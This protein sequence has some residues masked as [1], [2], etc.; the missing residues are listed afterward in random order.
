MDVLGF[1]GRGVWKCSVCL[2]DADLP[3]D[4]ET[5]KT[6]EVQI[7]DKHK[8]TRMRKVRKVQKKK[9]KANKAVFGDVRLLIIVIVFF[10]LLLLCT[11]LAF[12]VLCVVSCFL[13]SDVLR[14]SMLCPLRRALRHGLRGCASLPL[15]TTCRNRTFDFSGTRALSTNVT[16]TATST[17]YKVARPKATQVGKR[18]FTVGTQFCQLKLGLWVRFTKAW[19]QTASD[20]GGRFSTGLQTLRSCPFIPATIE[21][22]S[23][24]HG[25]RMLLG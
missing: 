9:N 25:R 6:Q 18:Q 14:V 17:G 16:T 3:R 4:C 11:L 8:E 10:V 23:H 2:D 21:P 20:H 22:P 24:C 7:R 13:F 19:A 5:R 1:R 12:L 15:Y